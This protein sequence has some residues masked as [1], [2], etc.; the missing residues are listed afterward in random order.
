MGRD[1]KYVL[2]PFYKD[3]TAHAIRCEGLISEACVNN[4]QAPTQKKEHEKN[5]CCKKYKECRLFKALEEKY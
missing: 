4:F 2:C 3:E 5:I 1:S